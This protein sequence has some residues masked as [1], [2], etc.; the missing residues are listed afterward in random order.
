MTKM[1]AS[2]PWKKLKR[3]RLILLDVDGILTDG[4]IYI[5]TGPA[6]SLLELKAFHAHDGQ[7]LVFAGEMGFVTGLVTSRASELVVQRAKE[8]RIPHVFQNVKDKRTAVRAFLKENGYKPEHLLYMGDDFV[9]LPVL[10]DAGFSVSVPG[11]PLE[12]RRRVDYVTDARGGRGAVR[13]VLE[14]LFKVQGKWAG[15]VKKY[16][17]P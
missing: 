11:A 9:D 7:G 3:I 2:V 4:R 1:Q 17:R 8:L 13:E 14:M 12:I 6:G 16:T 5:G 15:L 10:L